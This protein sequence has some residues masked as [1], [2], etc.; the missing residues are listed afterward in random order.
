MKKMFTLL[1]LLMLFRVLM[2][3]SAEAASI[4]G[5]AVNI[6]QFGHVTLDIS[7]E[8][9]N[10][11]GFSLGDVVTVRTGSFERSMPYL[12]SYYVDEGEYM[13]LDGSE[14]WG[15]ALCINC[16]NFA[17]EAGMQPGGHVTLTLKEKAGA[18]TV[19]EDNNLVYSNQRE[20]FSSDEI[21]ANFR[22]VID[23]ILYRSASPA[24]NRFNRA[25]T[26]DRLIQEA[27][28]RTVLN[29]ANTE[30]ELAKITA[31]EDFSS[32]FY[33]KLYQ[34]GSVITVWTGTELIPLKSGEFAESLVKGFSFLADRETPF[35]V[36]CTEG[37][38]RAGFAA[39]VLE[40]LAGFTADE[41][42]DDYMISY[43]NYYGL[44]PGTEQYQR[45]AEKNIV[46]E[47]L[48]VAGL[49]KAADLGSIEWR[50]AAE[51][52]LISHGMSREAV[53]RLEA[54]LTGSENPSPSSRSAS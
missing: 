3:A 6:S 39:M 31:A 46:E 27:G 20:D 4:S 36:H 12:S 35:L 14:E 30:E 16:G 54:K 24:D 13:I 9:F 25:A 23:G 29:M 41:I 45:I 11:A 44:E 40:M 32:A 34:A 33:R 10:D 52:Y 8:S 43:R 47:M 5:K 2:T 7:K 1:A 50:A 53:D 48:F 49:D 15:I 17:E 22:P 37:K 19:E 28:I 26:A 18:L 42:I 21:F 38:D 51:R